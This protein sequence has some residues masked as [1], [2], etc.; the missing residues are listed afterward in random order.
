MIL[1]GIEYK[2]IP[3]KHY[4]SCDGCA[5][6]QPDQKIKCYFR[7]LAINVE[8]DNKIWVK[9]LKPFEVINPG[10]AT[11]IDNGVTNENL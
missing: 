5:F 4:K 10:V 3:E 8:C 6:E 7:T 11:R 9:V 2:Q 1:D